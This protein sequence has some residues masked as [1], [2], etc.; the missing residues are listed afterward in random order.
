MREPILQLSYYNA[1]FFPLYHLG[2]M[3]ELGRNFLWQWSEKPKITANDQEWLTMIGW[4]GIMSNDLQWLGMTGN[5]GEWPGMTGNDREWLEMTRNDRE[6]PG[7]TGNDQKW[8][9]MT[10]NHQR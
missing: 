5:D 9:R 8:S 2:Y 3:C 1:P 4:L 6:W 7:M 10:A